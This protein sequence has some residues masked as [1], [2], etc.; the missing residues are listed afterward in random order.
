V[1]KKREAKAMKIWWV[2]IA[3]LAITGG[4]L[5]MIAFATEFPFSP[6]VKDLEHSDVKALGLFSGYQVWLY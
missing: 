2:T 5:G 3:Y 4:S 6:R 1:K